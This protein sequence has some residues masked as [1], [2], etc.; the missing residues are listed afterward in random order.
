[1]TERLRRKTERLVFSLHEQQRALWKRR[2]QRQHADVLRAR[3]GQE[4]ILR[5]EADAKTAAHQRK[6]LIGSRN[7][8][9]RLEGG[10]L[11]QKIG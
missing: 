3:F 7:L 1:M 4:K 5:N 2:R 10:A 8:D 9:V 6:D 11:M